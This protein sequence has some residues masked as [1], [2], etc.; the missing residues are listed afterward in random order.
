VRLLHLTTEFPPVIWGGLG[1]A[2][3]GIVRASARAGITVGVLLVGGVLSADGSYSG[4][5]PVPDKALPFGLGRI[6]KTSDGVTFFHVAPHDGINAGLRFARAWQP[7][8]VHLHSSWLWPVASAIREECGTPIVFTVHS[9]DRAEYE[10]GGFVTHWEPQEAVIQAV[11]RIIAISE[12][13][14]QLLTQYCPTVSR[15][16]RVIGNGIDDTSAARAAAQRRRSG[17]PLVMFSGR[18]VDRKGIHE[19]LEA[20][21]RVLTAEPDARFVLVGGYG[22]AN[23]TERTWFSEPLLTFRKKI[24]F[25]GWLPPAEVMRC[26]AAADILVVPS[27]YEPFGMVILEGMLH[28]L[29][30]AA[31]GIGGPAE[32][33]RH[34]TT[35]L[36]IPPR[37]VDALVAALLRLVSDANLRQCL[38]VAAAAAVRRRWLWPGLIADMRSVYGEVAN[39]K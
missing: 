31:S 15:R 11:D 33:L 39:A 23:D 28:G 12:S 16:V 1:T 17:P 27:W 37:N 8:V 4:W 38:G 13:E 22:T 3:G 24:R 21:P 18:F 29:A 6:V 7:D 10:W 20:I 35:G 36:L 30:I 32:I 26:Y 5:Q 14:R 25:T 34:E 19:L 9:L 2:V